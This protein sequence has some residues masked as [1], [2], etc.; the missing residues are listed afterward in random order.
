ME[1]APIARE[2]ETSGTII[3]FIRLINIPPKN[4]RTESITTSFTNEFCAKGLSIN[5]NIIPSASPII[6]L[7]VKPSFFI[8]FLIV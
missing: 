4:A 1:A 7:V 5:P 6:I 3:T 2:M 8:N